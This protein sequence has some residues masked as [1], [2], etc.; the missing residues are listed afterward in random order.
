M[1]IVIIT[2]NFI[3][4]III[5]IVII[6]IIIFTI[7]GGSSGNKRSIISDIYTIANLSWRLRQDF[8]SITSCVYSR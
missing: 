4:I 7:N 8:A 2:I 6:I 1:S 3:I 5:I